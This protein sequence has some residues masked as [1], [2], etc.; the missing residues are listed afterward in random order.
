MMGTW[1]RA[2]AA[3]DVEPDDLYRFDQNG[4]TFLVIRSPEDEYFCIDGICTHEKVNLADG[5]VMDGT[6]ECPKHSGHFNY[7]T[8][9]A[10]RAPACI[11][12]NTWPVRIENGDILI[13]I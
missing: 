4:R 1:T 11:N 3:D 12:L 7:K 13:E 9:E 5:L 2:C 8:G 10:V 6:I